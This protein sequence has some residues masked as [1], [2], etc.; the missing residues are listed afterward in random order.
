M[1]WFIPHLVCHQSKSYLKLLSIFNFNLKTWN[2]FYSS[3]ETQVDA[4]EDQVIM[5]TGD[6]FKIIRDARKHITSQLVSSK[7]YV[8]NLEYPGYK[9]KYLSGVNF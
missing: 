4:V 5:L 7:G 3:E 1:S 8:F 9:W 2:F 6:I